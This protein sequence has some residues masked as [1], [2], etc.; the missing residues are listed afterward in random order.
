MAAS[1]SS[2]NTQNKQVGFDEEVVETPAS[3]T[4]SSISSR[5]SDRLRRSSLPSSVLHRTRSGGVTGS[6]VPRVTTK[7][8][9]MLEKQVPR[10]SPLPRRKTK[11]Y[12]DPYQ[13][14]DEEDLM[15]ESR[16]S[17]SAVRSSASLQSMQLSG[18][19]SNQYH[20]HTAANVRANR[21]QVLDH[22]TVENDSLKCKHCGEVG[23]STIRTRGYVQ[24]RLS[25]ISREMRCLIEINK[26]HVHPLLAVL[27]IRDGLINATEEHRFTRSIVLVRFM[28]R[29]LFQVKKASHDSDAN[30]RKHLAYRHKDLVKNVL[31]PSQARLRERRLASAPSLSTHRIEELHY[32]A[33][34]CIAMDMRPLNDFRKEGMRGFLRVAFNGAYKGP[35]A[36]TVRS[37]LAMLYVQY[38]QDLQRAFSTVPYVSLTTDIWSHRRFSYIC[39]TAHCMTNQFETV[40]VL[41]GF[42]RIQGSHTGA[43]IRDYILY[44]LKRSGIESYK[45]TSITTDNASNMKAAASSFELGERF[46]CMAHNL[47]LIVTKGVCLWHEPKRDQ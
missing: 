7:R 17:E 19:D 11:T 21:A 12:A 8:L 18:S 26:R 25:C 13:S 27:Y 22:F 20:K 32:A 6:S 2:I 4:T 39:V 38:R 9:A 14:T 28:P 23:L 44:E 30:L 43:A 41:I 33:I 16:I 36:R 29:L 24:S 40:S 34:Q 45:V 35:C 47:H 31:F 37:N 5:H 1:I 3:A 46:S 42:R 15:I 10:S